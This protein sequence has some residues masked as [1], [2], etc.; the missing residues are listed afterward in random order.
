MT[1]KEKEIAITTF[2]DVAKLPIQERMKYEI[3]NEI[4]LFD[5]VIEQG[6]RSL[7][8][9]ESGRIGGL[10]ASRSKKKSSDK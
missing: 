7:S 3:A 8:A 4:G 6:W 1:K 2:E 10:L 9:R 5:K